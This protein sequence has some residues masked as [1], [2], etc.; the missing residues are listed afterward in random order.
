MDNETKSSSSFLTRF[1]RAF[2]VLLRVVF[3]LAIVT[4]IGWAI[5]A[6]IPYLNEKII[7]PIE[8]NTA[9]LTELES[10]DTQISDMQKR[11][12]DLENKQT[13]NVQNVA[14]MQE[15][16]EALEG[17]IEAQGETLKSLDEIEASLNTLLKTSEERETS[18]VNGISAIN[19]MQRQISLSRSVELLSR[20]QLYLSQNNFGLAKKDVENARDLLLDL[21]AE[22]TEE[23]AETLALVIEKLNF[24]I[25][26]LP[27]HPIIIVDSVNIA[28]ELLVNDLPDLPD[29]PEAIEE[30]KTP[31]PEAEATPTES[32]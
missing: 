26:N 31:T 30:P 24:A 29:L 20:A 25:N 15:E 2:W 9:R 12:A 6:G 8:K 27:E 28:W 18:L 22:I 17:A 16:V 21:Q 11:I 13:E 3:F 7:L 4:I 10:L 32:P 5:Y 14:E 1:G 19:D 23:K